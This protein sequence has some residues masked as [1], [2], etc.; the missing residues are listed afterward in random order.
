MRRDRT[1][2]IELNDRLRTT[3]KDGRVQMMPSAYDLEPRLCGRVLFALSK[4]RK[5]DDESEHDHG[6]FTFAGY[7]FEWHIEYRSTDDAGPSDNPGD[8]E[9]TLRVLTLY[10]IADLLK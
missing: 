8:S 2:I 5:F 1:R 10:V 7:L 9:R 3:F 6:T 4:Y